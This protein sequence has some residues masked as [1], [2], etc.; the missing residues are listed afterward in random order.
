MFFQNTILLQAKV[1][2]VEELY[3]NECIAMQHKSLITDLN[4]EKKN[5]TYYIY[6]KKQLLPSP[7][8]TYLIFTRD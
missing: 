7:V 5:I 2:A 4:T 6:I 8:S 3:F 1:T